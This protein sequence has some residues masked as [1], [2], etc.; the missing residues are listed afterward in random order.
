MLQFCSSQCQ[1]FFHTTLAQKVPTSYSVGSFYIKKD[2][3]IQSF[4][5]F[6]FF[7][8]GLEPTVRVQRERAEAGALLRLCCKHISKTRNAVKCERARR[9]WEF[10]IGF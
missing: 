7:G 5:M 6:K 4:F 8:L 1:Q 2:W 9:P 3:F 10:F